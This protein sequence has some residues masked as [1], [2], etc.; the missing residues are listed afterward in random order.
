MQITWAVYSSRRNLPPPARHVFRS[1]DFK[2]NRS[3]RNPPHSVS[4]R[5]TPSP[6]HPF[7]LPSFITS[8]RLSHSALHPR[9]AVLSTEPVKT[10]LGF[11]HCDGTRWLSRYSDQAPGCIIE[12]ESQQVKTFLAFPNRPNRAWG[13]PNSLHN[14]YRRFSPGVKRLGREAHHSPASN[15]EVKNERSCTSAPSI[16]LCGVCRENYMAFTRE[17][18]WTFQFCGVWRCV[19]GRRSVG[20]YCLRLQ[21]F[22][23]FNA[24]DKDAIRSHFVLNPQYSAIIILPNDVRYWRHIPHE[25]NRGEKLR[26]N[27]HYFIV[28]L[29]R[30][31]HGLVKQ[32]RRLG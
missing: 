21:G 27:K 18:F 12:F 9:L 28:R 26:S 6:S 10:S 17:L 14:G 1:A 20:V 8:P 19:V 30:W 22:S 11:G 29:L 7:I 15:V 24:P 5:L 31:R 2:A 4:T 25:V 23:Q 13:P 3:R 32:C 16:Y